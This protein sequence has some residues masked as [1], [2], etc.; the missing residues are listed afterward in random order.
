MF[1]DGMELEFRK[2]ID[3]SLWQ[4]W[5]AHIGVSKARLARIIE[6]SLATAF[7]NAAREHAD[8]VPSEHQSHL[9]NISY[10][11]AQAHPQHE[12]D[13]ESQSES[14]SEAESEAESSS[15][16]SEASQQQ[17]LQQKQEFLEQFRCL[18]EDLTSRMKAWKAEKAAKDRAQERA[19]C[20][21]EEEPMRP[22]AG[23][24]ELQEAF[25]L[26]TWMWCFA[27]GHVLWGPDRARFAGIVRR[28]RMGSVADDMLY[29]FKVRLTYSE[30]CN[31][32]LPMQ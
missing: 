16:S 8:E 7:L 31:L 17:K 20:S 27:R 18:C 24:K 4:L 21:G 9:E 6:P 29:I 3:R 10:H 13:V 15:A 25:A 14:E 11:L 23:K 19:R 2:P 1:L 26:A 30:W 5:A 22:T 32:K 28:L 12:C